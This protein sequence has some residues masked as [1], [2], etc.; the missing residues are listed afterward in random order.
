[1]AA[2]LAPVAAAW[3]LRAELDSLN[4][5]R[6][7]DLPFPE[8]ARTPGAGAL[9]RHRAQRPYSCHCSG[10]SSGFGSG[11]AAGGA[12]GVVPGWVAGASGGAWG[13]GAGVSC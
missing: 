12:S 11:G 8:V 7:A 13:S 3:L 2:G 1:M 4:G 10:F 9:R 6:H 5:D